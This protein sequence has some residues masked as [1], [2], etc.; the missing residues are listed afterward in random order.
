MKTITYWLFVSLLL[1]GCATRVVGLRK[2]ES[3]NFQNVKTGR[4]AI[5]GVASVVEP[6]KPRMRSTYGNLLKTQMIEER[7]TIPVLSVGSFQKKIGS[8]QYSQLMNE[9]EELGTINTTWIKK[10]KAK[11]KRGRFVVFALIESN[12]IDFA[13]DS[14]SGYDDSSREY[15]EAKASRTISASLQVLDL[16]AEEVAW[17][18]S[19][20]KT[21][22]NTN[23]YRK[24]KEM[25]LISLVKAIKGDERSEDEK[26][27]FPDAPKTKEVLAR[28]FS[29]FS[30][31]LPETDK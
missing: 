29:G 14:R 11:Y 20:T 3:F 23:N 27:P 17:S 9:Y 8:D 16:Q 24:K 10:I 15:V 12:D 19:I 5:G 4:M 22:A 18:G 21:V 28:L 6:L 7:K 30:E 31:N 2:S 1:S 25:G 13:R 26:Y